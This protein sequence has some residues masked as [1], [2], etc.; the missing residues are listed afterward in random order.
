VTSKEAKLD[1][2][3]N[4][5]L[6]SPEEQV[7]RL[8]R[9]V[10]ISAIAKMNPPAFGSDEVCNLH[11]MPRNS[12]LLDLASHQHKRGKWF[13]IFQ[14]KFTCQGGANNGAVCSPFGPDPNYPVPDICVGAPCGS[15]RTPRVGDCNVDM[16]VSV[17][18]LVTGLDMAM[19]E[20]GTGECPRFEGND[21]GKV[22]IYELF[23]AV[24]AAVGPRFR[25][26]EESL[27]YSTTTYADPLILALH[28]PLRLGGRY[29]TDEE[30]TLTYCGLYDNGFANP[31]E[32]KRRSTAPE[33]SACTPTHCAD[34]MVGVPCGGG[35]S[36]E[37]DRSCDSSP[38]AGDGLCDACRV[39]F[40]VTTD[41]EM[42]VLVGSYV[43]D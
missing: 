1:M 27:L 37:R 3:I 23:A 42:F 31:D 28:P 6:A 11:V 2:W 38:G 18:E 5:D 14:G 22:T 36:I 10:D 12:R 17:D 35:S 21:D 13:R 41:D 25:D 9:F 29:S 33:R 24:D 15:R 26:A 40:G 19:N 4:F 20:S 30:R 43:I 7:R 16:T 32:V 39:G 34:G 8:E